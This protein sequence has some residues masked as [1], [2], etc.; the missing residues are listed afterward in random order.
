[1]VRNIFIVMLVYFFIYININYEKF[2][3]NIVI[4]CIV[5]IDMIFWL[6]FYLRILFYNLFFFYKN[7]YIRF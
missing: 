2:I 5:L 3:F 6:K 1:M 4:Y 7:F